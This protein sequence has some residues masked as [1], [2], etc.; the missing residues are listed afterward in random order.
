MKQDSVSGMKSK[1]T[2]LI[3]KP[4]GCVTRIVV[5]PYQIWGTKKK[6]ERRS[7]TRVLVRLIVWYGTK[8]FW[9][10]RQR[11]NSEGL[12]GKKRAGGCTSGRQ[13]ENILDQQED[14]GNSGTC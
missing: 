14:G 6:R 13:E 3:P 10:S 8:R 1:D 11:G 2:L 9:I 4:T 7:V 12:G 5:I